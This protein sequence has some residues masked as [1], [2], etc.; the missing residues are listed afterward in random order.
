[1]N[2]PFD[3][4]VWDAGECAEYLR[5]AKPSFLKRTQWAPGFPPRLRGFGQPRWQALAVTEWALFG[6]KSRQNP[7]TTEAMA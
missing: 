2:V 1:V 4:V 3:R 5:I 6:N 7:A